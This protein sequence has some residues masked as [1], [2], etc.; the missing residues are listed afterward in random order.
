[1]SDRFVILCDTPEPRFIDFFVVQGLVS[2]KP[3]TGTADNKWE[4]VND[5]HRHY[6]KW[7]KG[8]NRPP[9]SNTVFAKKL[10]EQGI[11][12]G[13]SLFGWWLDS[14]LSYSTFFS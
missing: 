14:S 7:C 13:K 3:L 6:V 5:L 2:L 1:M 8:N 10:Y 11:L 12:D 9:V 4:Q